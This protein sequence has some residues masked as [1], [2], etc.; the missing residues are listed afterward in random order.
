MGLITSGGSK[1]G[2]RE[3]RVSSLVLDQT[4]ARRAEKILGDCPSPP[5][6]PP[7]YL[8]VWMTGP[9]SYLKVWIRY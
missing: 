9:P 8:K 3:A 2:A 1:G 6:P 4:E 5:P 7:P